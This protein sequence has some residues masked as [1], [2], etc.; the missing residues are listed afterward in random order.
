[1]TNPNR[2]W[3][4]MNAFFF[5]GIGELIV[6]ILMIV[7]RKSWGVGFCRLGKAILKGTKYED[8]YLI[9]SIYDESEAPGAC[10]IMGIIVMLMS[11]PIIILGLVGDN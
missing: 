1:M 8:N 6:G 9:R 11:L 2:K 10:L 7:F 5:V 4:R 3:L